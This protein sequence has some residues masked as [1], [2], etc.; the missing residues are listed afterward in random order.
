MREILKMKIEGDAVILD[1]RII[2]SWLCDRLRKLYENRDGCNDYGFVTEIELGE[3]LGLLGV[4]GLNRETWKEIS[5]AKIA[6]TDE[7]IYQA[8]QAVIREFGTSEFKDYRE[9]KVLENL[10][11]AV[12]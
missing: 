1:K 12:L 10:G 6:P 8:Y 11:G 4:L 3:L 5:N 7:N 9:F 2:A